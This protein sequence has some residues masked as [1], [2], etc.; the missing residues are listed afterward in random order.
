M[1][2]CQLLYRQHRTS[3]SNE[4]D[5]EAALINRLSSPIGMRPKPD[6]HFSLERVTGCAQACA[7]NMPCQTAATRARHPAQDAVAAHP[8][9]D[10]KTAFC[11][12]PP[13]KMIIIARRP[14]GYGQRYQNRSPALRASFG[15]E[16]AAISFWSAG[17]NRSR[18]FA[19]SMLL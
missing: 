11:Q 5:C 6:Q 16:R 14:S 13:A 2:F 9:R 8:R 17:Y 1:R 4:Q 15:S 12:Q 18:R 19:P 10:A 3:F 7:N